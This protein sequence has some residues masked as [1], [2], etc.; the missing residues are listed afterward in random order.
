MLERAK[1]LYFGSVCESNCIKHTL[2]YLP[3]RIWIPIAIPTANQM[4]ILYYAELFILYGVRFQ[5]QQEWN[6]NPDQ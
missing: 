4:A 3:G 6:R 1:L 2:A 5:S